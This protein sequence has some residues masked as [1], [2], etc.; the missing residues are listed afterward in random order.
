MAPTV[1]GFPKDGIK[2]LLEDF[3]AAVGFEGQ[4]RS[5]DGNC[6]LHEECSYNGLRLH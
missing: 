6:V 2:I 1:T 5:A 3:S 4:D